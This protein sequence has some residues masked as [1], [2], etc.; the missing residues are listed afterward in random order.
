MAKATI[1]KPEPAP[2]PEDKIV[3]ELSLLE[4]RLLRALAG[5]GVTGGGV[6]LVECDALNSIWTSLAGVVR[7]GYVIHDQIRVERVAS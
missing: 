5:A 1:V 6:G 3:L 2:P 7:P 4:A